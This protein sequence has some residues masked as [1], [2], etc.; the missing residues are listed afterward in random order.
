MRACG[1]SECV[2]EVLDEVPVLVLESV[3]G[4]S[5]VVRV[6]MFGVVVDVGVAVAAQETTRDR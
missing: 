6:V 3:G 4:A 2:A 1:R 5:A